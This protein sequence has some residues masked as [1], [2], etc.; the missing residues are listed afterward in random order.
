MGFTIYFQPTKY[1]KNQFETFSSMLYFIIRFYR[2]LIQSHGVTCDASLRLWRHLSTWNARRTLAVITS[3]Q[4][5]IALRK[6]T[7]RR[8]ILYKMKKV[9]SFRGTF[10]HMAKETMV[11]LFLECDVITIFFLFQI[12]QKY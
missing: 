10:C 12:R 8:R 4:I 2:Q 1:Q 5:Q 9:A 11:Q 3:R 6:G 7:E